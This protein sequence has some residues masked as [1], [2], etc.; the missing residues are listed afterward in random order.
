MVSYTTS[1]TWSDG[2]QRACSSPVLIIRV[3]I[4]PIIPPL[5]TLLGRWVQAKA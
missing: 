1:T 2:Y 5:L 4:Q 3:I